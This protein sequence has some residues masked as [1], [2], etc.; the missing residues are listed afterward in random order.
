MEALQ[1]KK[2][3]EEFWEESLGKFS[4]GLSEASPKEIVTQFLEQLL[5]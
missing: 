4:E 5:D 1:E 2:S 3:L